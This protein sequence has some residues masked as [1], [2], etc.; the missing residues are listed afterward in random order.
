MCGP[1]AFILPVDKSSKSKMIGQ[2]LLYHFGRLLTYSIIGL[3]F[4]LIGKGLYLS[5]FQQRLSIL[6]GVIMILTIIIP[7]K[8][9]NKF[10]LTKPLYQN[11]GKVKSKLGL[12]LKQKSNKALFLI[13]FFNGFLPCGL[14]YMAVIGAIS[15]GNILSGAL[16]MF[17]FGIGTIP[18]MTGAVYLGNFLKISV[19]SKIQK[20]IPIFVV[21][22]GLLFILR[23]M[24]LGIPYIS[25]SDT[26]LHLSNNPATCITE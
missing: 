13:G 9:L 1:I 17:I 5:G 3:L 7:T 18:L 6:M 20:A 25:P 8:Y 16:Y 15:S 4:G 19:R 12:Y 2:T 24:G 26:K 10:N 14:V 23:G 21:M 11:I 22:I